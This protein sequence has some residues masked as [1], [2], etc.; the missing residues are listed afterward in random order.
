MFNEFLEQ[1][2]L[3][4]E[5]QGPYQQGLLVT[6]VGMLMVFG[7]LAVMAF[8]LW[9]LRTVFPQKVIKRLQPVIQPGLDVAGAMVKPVLK[10]VG[11]ERRHTLSSYHFIIIALLYHH[12]HHRLGAKINLHRTIDTDWRY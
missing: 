7:L 3:S 6:A 11:E 1:V 5:L 9:A 12:Q 2:R 8:I 4:L 10:A